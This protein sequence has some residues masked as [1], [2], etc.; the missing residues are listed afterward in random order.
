M[1]KYVSG[2]R[3][4]LL[5]QRQVTVILLIM[6]RWVFF[7]HIPLSELQVRCVVDHCRAAAVQ[8]LPLQTEAGH[9]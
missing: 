2:L 7:A 6:M 9:R 4:N 1:C 3:T 5:P 8:T